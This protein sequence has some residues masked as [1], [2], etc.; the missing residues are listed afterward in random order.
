V[1]RWDTDPLGGSMLKVR[2][3]MTAELIVLDP[4]LT[5]RNAVDLLAQRRISGAPV[6]AGGR[7]VGVL[8]AMDILA[9]EASVPGVPTDQPEFQEQGE[10]ETEEEEEKA[11]VVEGEEAPSA[12]FTDLWS[13]AGAD[14]VERFS[15]THGPEWDFLGEHT[16]AEAMS[17]GVRTIPADA[18]VKAAAAGMRDDRIHRLLVMERKTLVGIVTALDIVSAVAD[19][20]V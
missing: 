18:S 14:L 15:A 3:I 6:M 8:S 10:A 9:F 4:G 12:Y 7:V 1:S 16:V 13:D 17:S 20:R 5:L 19:G 2:D 11:M